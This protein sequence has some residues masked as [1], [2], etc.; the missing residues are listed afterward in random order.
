LKINVYSENNQTIIAMAMPTKL[1]DLI[2]T[3]A[4]ELALDIENQLKEVIDLSVK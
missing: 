4:N 1:V 2:E 3:S